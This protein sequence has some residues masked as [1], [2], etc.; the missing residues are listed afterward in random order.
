M[1]DT[2]IT[3][4]YG[5]KQTDKLRDGSFDTIELGGEIAFEVD[6][7]RDPFEFWEKA[8]SRLAEQVEG[9]L[10]Q[11]E[12]RQTGSHEARPQ[13]DAPEQQPAQ[14]SG[15]PG[16]V[17]REVKKNTETIRDGIARQTQ[18]PGEKISGGGQTIDEYGTPSTSVIVPNEAVMFSKCRVFEV[19]AKKA[20]NG[21]P[22]V[23]VR[24]GKRGEDGIPGQYTTARSFESD[25]I[26][27]VAYFD[28]EDGWQYK[29]R[30]GDYVDVWG[31]FKPWK[32]NPEKFD[33]ELQKVQIHEE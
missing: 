19:E 15:G 24:I 21:N 7:E 33:L 12:P 26:K 4:R 6:E 11:Y 1:G 14:S 31:Y 13:L 10:A 27:Q 3:V 29:I 30:N 23:S 32:G 18:L 2:T 28:P 25:V 8:Y 22:F 20:S 9:A 17:E 16:W 5:R